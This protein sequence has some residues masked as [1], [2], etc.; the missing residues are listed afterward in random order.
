MTYEREERR[1]SGGGR[2]AGIIVVLIVIGGFAAI[3]MVVLFMRQRAVGRREARKKAGA[4]AALA[5]AGQGRAM[6]EEYLKFK[7]ANPDKLWPPRK[8]KPGE[9]DPDGTLAIEDAVVLY[10]SVLIASSSSRPTALKGMPEPGSDPQVQVLRGTYAKGGKAIPCY[11]FKA[12]FKATGGREEGSARIIIS[13][14]E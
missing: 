7:S 1:P 4:E 6:V 14:E 11:Q 13:L 9:L 12:P 3:A 5:L 8:L 10:G 2:A